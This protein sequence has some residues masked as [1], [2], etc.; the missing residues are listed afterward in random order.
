MTE[1]NRLT[2]RPLTAAGAHQIEHWFE[3][4]ETRHWLGGPAWIRREVRLVPQRVGEEYQGMTTLR[5]YGWVVDDS[6]GVPIA[7]LAC[8]VQDRW[9]RQDG[10]DAGPVELIDPRRAASLMY[11]VDP[12][13]WGRGFGR[14]LLEAVIARPELTDVEAFYCGIDS[15]N[16]ASRRCAVAAG[17]TLMSSEPDAENTLYFRRERR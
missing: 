8:S 11:A 3:H 17:F 4:P 13:R 14:A 9:L 15:D 5:S 16:T 1:P 7:Y 10:P 12:Q 6:A 2:F